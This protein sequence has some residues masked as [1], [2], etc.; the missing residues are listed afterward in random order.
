[1]AFCACHCHRAALP[2]A[3]PVTLGAVRRHTFCER[4]TTATTDGRPFKTFGRLLHPPHGAPFM[5][6][7]R[8]A[9]L[10]RALLEVGLLTC[11]LHRFVDRLIERSDNSVF[12]A[13]TCA[14][15]ADESAARLCPSPSPALR[16]R[17]PR[18]LVVPVGPLALLTLLPLWLSL[19]ALGLTLPVLLL[20][21]L[22][23]GTRLPG[24]R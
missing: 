19:V 22:L 20:A 15:R 1:M 16:T 18:R 21:L 24:L 12:H 23:T 2:A 6:R 7:L 9:A 11:Q 10:P 8:V 5:H 4:W 17:C 3:L 13:S 14:S